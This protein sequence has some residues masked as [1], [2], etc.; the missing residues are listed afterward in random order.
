MTI[1]IVYMTL[2]IIDSCY[3]DM[4]KFSHSIILK[5]FIKRSSAMSEALKLYLS[6]IKITGKY[7]KY[8]GCDFFK[9]GF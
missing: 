7:F 2:K 6:E 9:E 5:P 4:L 1:N 3:F 8:F